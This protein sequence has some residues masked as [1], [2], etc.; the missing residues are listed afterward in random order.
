M[1]AGCGIE[2][3]RTG[4]RWRR[5]PPGTSSTAAA[6]TP[7]TASAWSAR[8]RSWHLLPRARGARSRTSTR[9]ARRTT[10][11]AS[12]TSWMR[13][14]DRAGR[15]RLRPA[16]DGLASAARGRRTR[17]L[18]ML[19]EAHCG[20]WRRHAPGDPDG[21]RRRPRSRPGCAVTRSRPRS[22]WSSAATTIPARLG[23]APTGAGE[24]RDGHARPRAGD[25]GVGGWRGP[26]RPSGAGAGAGAPAGVRRGGAG[27]TD[28]DKTQAGRLRGPPALPQECT[29]CLGGEA[30]H[31]CARRGS[32]CGRRCSC[33][34][35]PWRR[36]CRC[37]R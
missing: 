29:A 33:A 11:R 26:H 16:R 15:P 25:A 27:A 14:G 6:A 13:S 36:P 32:S 4:C 34:G 20:C 12:S 28:A 1:A 2:P 21:R 23:T 18:Y 30:R 17:V 3:R 9:C 19:Q 7:S 22:C 35:C 8:S 31:A 5:P 37:A 24:R 10:R